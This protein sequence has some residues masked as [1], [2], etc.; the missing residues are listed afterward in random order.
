MMTKGIREKI[1]N[2]LTDPQNN[3][4]EF[5]NNLIP[6][7]W[8]EKRGLAQTLAGFGVGVLISVTALGPSLAAGLLTPEKTIDNLS[9]TIAVVGNYTANRI[10]DPSLFK[11]DLKVVTKA[12][13]DFIDQNPYESAKSI[14]KITGDAE[15]AALGSGY[16]VADI[17]FES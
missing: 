6:Q 13:N 14:G 5:V 9:Q 1:A 7:S 11:S 8:K 2:A 3:L 15:I 17:C 10:E 12:T 16:G 4:G